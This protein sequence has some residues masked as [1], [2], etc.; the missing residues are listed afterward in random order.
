MAPPRL[1][2]EP[3][4]PQASS[5][6]PP[7]ARPSNGPDGRQRPR[8]K[9]VLCFD[10]TGNKFQG[11]DGDSNILKI[12]RMLDRQTDQQCKSS[13]FRSNQRVIGRLIKGH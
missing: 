6:D 5:V 8:K 3:Y 4:R 9:F 12:F 11:N 1:G 10:G 7:E 13:L 2:D